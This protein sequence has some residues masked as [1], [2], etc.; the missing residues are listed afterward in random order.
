MA[1]DPA[2]SLA[3]ALEPFAG[4]G[5]FSP[6]CHR[7]YEALGFGPSGGEVGGVQMPEIAAYFTSRGS[8]MG[9]VPGEVVAAAFGVF[10]PAIV[11]PSVSA[12]W[13][14][15]DAP[16]IEAARTAGAVGQLTRVLG[17]QP[18]GIA[19][20][21]DAMRRATEHLEPAGKPLFAGLCAQAV[22]DGALG[23]AWRLADM[24]REYRGD[25]H[26]A[27][28]TAAGFDACEIGLL[29][30]LYWGLP[31]RSYSRTRGWDDDDYAAATER[32]EARGLVSDDSLT[33]AGRDERE[34]I[35]VATDEACRPI[36]DALGDD[37]PPLV[38]TLSSW[39][40]AVRDAKGYPAAGPVELAEAARR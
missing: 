37:L 3:A 6:E 32:L 22:P 40:A 25:A 38:E 14:K 36:V 16:T 31:A 30:E 2:R 24:L 39:S 7:G 34:S 29:T 27:V 28:W 5:Y 13:S 12:G 10:K 8:V 4:Q 11:I 9:Q 20:A 19:D 21:L 23:E 26:V 35:E 18:D 17:E 33:D 1:I 15:T